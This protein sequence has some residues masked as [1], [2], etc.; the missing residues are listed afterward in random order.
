MN[1]P[2]R[3]V[4]NLELKGEKYSFELDKESFELK[5]Y[6]LT[7]EDVCTK[8]F[9]AFKTLNLKVRENKWIDRITIQGVTSERYLVYFGTIDNPESYNGYYTYRVDWYYLTDEDSEMVDEMRFYSHEINYFFNPTRSFEKN[10]T[11]NTEEDVTLQSFSIHS[12]DCDALKCG[13]YIDNNI[14]V[15]ITCDSNSILHY[16]SPTPL[17]SESC[18]KLQFSEA[19]NIGKVVY[20]ARI[21]H[22]FLKYVCYRSN[23]RFSNISVYT[24]SDEGKQRNCGK[25]VFRY[26]G[27]EEK[28]EICR[29]R[30]IRAEYLN[31]RI[32]DIMKAINDNEIHLD[33]CCDSLKALSYYSI[34]RVI[35]ILATFEREYRNIYGYDVRRSVNYKCIKENVIQIIEKYAENLSGKNKKY[36]KSFAKRIKDYDVSYGDNVKFAFEDCREIMDVFIKKCFDESY[37]E[38][39]E[40]ISESINKLRNGIAHSRLDM[41][42]EPRHITDIKLIEEMLYVIRLKKLGIEVS[43]IQKVINELFGVGIII[44]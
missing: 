7:T 3:I 1:I 12:V 36:A 11:Y 29:K 35:M 9:E 27:D 16:E 24:T 28:S 18:L 44:K 26:Q 21:V 31:E 14:Q 6:H 32:A 39:V 22:N 38:A 33:Y 5:L 34:N 8:F 42:I 20:N 2:K 43:V 10:I 19:I 4:G 13:S 40:G 41:E 37:E 23:I 17:E 15:N 25:L 30:I